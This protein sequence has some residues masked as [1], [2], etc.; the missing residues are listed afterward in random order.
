L[1]DGGR[2]K[3]SSNSNTQAGR[4]KEHRVFRN[5][6]HK[7]K[8]LCLRTLG[9]DLLRNQPRLWVKMALARRMAWVFR[10]CKISSRRCSVQSLKVE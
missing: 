2:V 10:Q 4:D 6:K 9:M 1:E 7:H 8:E 3:E 5:N